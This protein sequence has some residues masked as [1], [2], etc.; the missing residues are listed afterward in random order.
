MDIQQAVEVQLRTLENTV[1]SY[2]ANIRAGDDLAAD[3]LKRSIIGQLQKITDTRAAIRALAM[4]DMTAE[5][6]MDYV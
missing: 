6:A 4:T 1:V 3:R 2:C 5:D